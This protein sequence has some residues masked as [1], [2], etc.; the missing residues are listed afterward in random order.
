M[1]EQICVSQKAKS[2]A[3]VA[4]GMSEESSLAE[5]M[6]E[7]KQTIDDE[8]K[9]IATRLA[10]LEDA[11]VST[12]S[13]FSSEASDFVM[14]SDSATSVQVPDVLLLVSWQEFILR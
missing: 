1:L 2:V 9:M 14:S 10:V 4:E 6:E 12:L 7:Q 3:R 8:L 13:R 11:S 5:Q